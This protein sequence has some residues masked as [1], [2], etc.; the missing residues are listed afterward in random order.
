MAESACFVEIIEAAFRL[1]KTP[2]DGR[3]P[4]E[5]SKGKGSFLNEVNK[6][7]LLREEGCREPGKRDQRARKKRNKSE[8]TVAFFVKF[9][10]DKD[11]EE[12]HI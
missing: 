9:Y 2:A 11:N 1:W 6:Q 7:G 8:E 3:S 10:Y 12:A 5:A 4:Q